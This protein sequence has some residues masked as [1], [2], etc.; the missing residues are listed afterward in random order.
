M[1]EKRKERRGELVADASR[2]DLGVTYA[3]ANR[4]RVV[5]AAVVLSRQAKG[6]SVSAVVVG[7]WGRSISSGDVRGT[8]RTR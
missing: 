2:R 1:K 7:P 8:L 6:P 4:E 5:S 3:R